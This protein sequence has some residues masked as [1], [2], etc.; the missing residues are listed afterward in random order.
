MDVSINKFDEKKLTE[1][2]NK[3]TLIELYDNLV[4]IFFLKLVAFSDV[5]DED[6]LSPLKKVVKDITKKHENMSDLSVTM[7]GIALQ[8]LNLEAIELIDLKFILHDMLE[9]IMTKGYELIGRKPINKI[10][11]QLNPTLAMKLDEIKELGVCYSILELLLKSS[12]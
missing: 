3:K 12:Y 10:I 8:S 4:N 11:A 1:L 6:F 2:I 7:S 9:K 5:L